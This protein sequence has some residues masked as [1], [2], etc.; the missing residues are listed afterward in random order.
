MDET[1][2]KI[3]CELGNGYFKLGKLKEAKQ[4]FEKAL[5]ENENSVIPYTGLAKIELKNRNLKK[6][7]EFLEK[8]KKIEKQNID[9]ILTLAELEYLKNNFENSYELA[10][11]VLENSEDNLEALSILQ[12][13]AYKLN[14]FDDL[15]KFLSIQ[16]SK[17]PSD[18]SI[19]FALCG[20][21]YFQDKLEEAKEYLEKLLIIDKD[22]KEAKDLIEIIDKKIKIKNEV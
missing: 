9:L 17:Q 6:A 20:C 2:F 4:N 11:K 14:K 18:K 15:E 13:S 1:K 10:L 8:A 7:E 16:H 22:N 5:K 3:L 19:L 12:K 21:L